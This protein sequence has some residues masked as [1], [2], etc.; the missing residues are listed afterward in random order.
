MGMSLVSCFFLRHSVY[1]FCASAPEFDNIYMR[2]VRIKNHNMWFIQEI[3]SLKKRYKRMT[4]FQEQIFVWM[5]CQFSAYCSNNV[6]TTSRMLPWCQ[7]CVS[8]PEFPVFSSKALRMEWSNGDFFFKISKFCRQFSKL[9]GIG[10]TDSNVLFQPFSPRTSDFSI[11]FIPLEKLYRPRLTMPRSLTLHRQLV[12]INSATLH[13]P[14]SKK[15]VKRWCHSS[16]YLE[17]YPAEQVCRFWCLAQQ[18]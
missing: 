5:L 14:V 15:R 3:F 11:P 1:C 4:A 6:I 13:T 12:H 2:V 10:I 8:F 18:C 9:T 16:R 17:V 7:L